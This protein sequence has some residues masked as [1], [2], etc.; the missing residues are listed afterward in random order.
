A[1]NGTAQKR[2]RDDQDHHQVGAG[3]GGRDLGRGRDLEHRQHEDGHRNLDRV[4]H[5]G[6]TFSTRTSLRS[7]KSTNGVIWMVWS[8]SPSEMPVLLTLP[9]GMPRGSTGW[10]GPA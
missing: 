2:Q 8:V 5:E 7:S 3:R 10:S 9:I 6:C 4:D 1:P